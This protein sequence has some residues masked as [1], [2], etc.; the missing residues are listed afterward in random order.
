TRELW[1]LRLA[2][3]TNQDIT[4]SQ[5]CWVEFYVPGYG[6]VVA[7]PADVRR[8]MLM[9][10]IKDVKDVKDLVE[11]YFGAVD[12]VR[13]AYYHGRDVMLNPPQSGPRLNYVMYPYAEVDGKP[14]NEDLYGFNIG[15]RITFSEK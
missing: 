2:K 11:Y 12:E 9:K 13:V 3:G 10:N 4:K 8:A 1:G 7:D 5:H 14:L 15:Y 6:W